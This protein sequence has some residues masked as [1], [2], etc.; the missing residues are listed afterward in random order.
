MYQLSKDYLDTF[1]VQNHGDILANFCIIISND[2]LSISSEF[3]KAKIFQRQL[4]K[5]K[6]IKFKNDPMLHA[7]YSADLENFDILNAH[8]RFTID[9]LTTLLK[10][11]TLKE[12][13]GR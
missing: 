8:S 7:Q 11:P 12:L 4:L 2:C 10:L 6:I 5:N 3:K 1:P 9:S 13:P